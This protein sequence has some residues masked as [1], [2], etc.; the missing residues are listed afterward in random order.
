MSQIETNVGK[1]IVS[2]LISYAATN[3]DDL[4]LLMNFFTEAA[5]GNSPM[6]VRNI[7]LGQYLGFLILLSFSL[8]GYFVSFVLPIEMLGFLGFVP[9]ILGL[10]EIVRWL[11]EF[12]RNRHG[13]IDEI[14]PTEPI[15]TVQLES[16]RYQNQ[17]ND[18][19]VFRIEKEKSTND[20]PDEKRPKGK[21]VKFLESFFSP[22]TLKVLMITLANSADNIAIY[23]A[24]FSQAARWQIVVYIV[25]FLLMLFVWLV[26]SFYFIN[27]PPILSLAEKIAPYLVPVVFLGIGLYIVIS[28]N[29]FHWLIEAIRTKNF[30][31]G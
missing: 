12:Y 2:A 4:V 28:S 31:N 6:K 3:I 14:L 20:E 7:F 1:L 11:I 21:F 13:K 10:K 27:F 17:S 8:I 18:E 16:I 25:I 30:H 22:E 29:C 19:V 23:T 15:S 5:I 24:L 9:I 26:A